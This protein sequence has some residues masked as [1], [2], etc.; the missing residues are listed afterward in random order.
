MT[1]EKTL[2]MQDHPATRHLAEDI[3]VQKHHP[4][5]KIFR[6]LFKVIEALW[7]CLQMAQ[8]LR[9]FFKK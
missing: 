8:C 7:M 3:H 1:K 2:F 6:F 4:R 5:R 9:E